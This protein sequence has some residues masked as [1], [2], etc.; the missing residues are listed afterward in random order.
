MRLDTSQHMAMEQRMVLAPRMIQSMEILQLPLLALQERIEQEMLANPVLEQEEPVDFEEIQTDPSSETGTETVTDSERV[1]RIGEDRNK[2]KEFERLDNVGDDYNDYLQRSLQVRARSGNGERD[3]KLEAMQN[4]AAPAQSLNEFLHGQWAFIECKQAIQRAGAI[5]IDHIDDSGYLSVPLESLHERAPEVKPAQWAEALQLVQTLEPTGVGARDLAE[6]M[7][8]QLV[9]E[10]EDR[11][12]EIE[13]VKNHLKDIE[14]NRY[15]LV[16]KR[17]GKS[18]AVIQEAVKVISRLDLRP[19]LQVG[20]HETPYI[21]PDIIVDYDEDNDTY[22][23]RLSDGSSPNL[24]INTMYAKMVKQGK[25][26]Q[27]AKEFLQN[28]IR[29]ARWIIES[30]EQRKTTLLRVVHHVLKSQREFFDHGPQHLRPLPMVDVADVLGIHVGTVSRAVS[31]KYMQTPIGIYPLRSFFSGGI[32]TAGGESVSWD[33]I[34]A[35]LREIVDHEDKKNPWND[36]QL[37]AE[38]TKRGL[39]VARRTV[40]KYRSILNIPPARRRKQFD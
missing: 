29:S 3:G 25:L 39:T 28:N 20:R 40:A 31:G 26:P 5:L 36:D 7:A 33:A 32:E 11:S 27:D 6:C 15:P 2:T 38:L 10:T 18:I 23:A 34:K 8:L 37:A 16:A 19:G 9:S 21:M 14:M 12:L 17:T 30:I 4:T 1:L 13:L 24:R 35:K 22:T